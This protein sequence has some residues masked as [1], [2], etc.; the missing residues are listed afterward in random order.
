MALLGDAALAMWWD[1]APAMRAEFEHWHGVEHV[2]ERLALPGFLRASRWADADGGPGVFVLYELAAPGDLASPAYLARLDAPTPWS[3]RLMP[4]HAHMVRC[5]SEVLASQGAATARHLLTLRWN[6]PQPGAA[7]LVQGARSVQ[8]VTGVH[9]LRHRP[10]AIAQTREQRLRGGGDGVAD[11]IVLVGGYDL[12]PLRRV[13]AQAPAG[14]V[15]G[16]YTLS[17]ARTR[18]DVGR[19]GPGA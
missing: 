12:A 13:A 18:E 7:A 4:H 19:D 3:V 14:A 16:C 6:D 15:V 5:Q 11:T 1:M 17:L 9:L 10:P 2:P 8:G